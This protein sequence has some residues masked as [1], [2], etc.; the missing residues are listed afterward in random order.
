MT[1]ITEITFLSPAA[2]RQAFTTHSLHFHSC[3]KQFICSRN[4]F[5]LMPSKWKNIRPRFAHA[6]RLSNLWCLFFSKGEWR[7]HQTQSL[8]KLSERPT[9][10]QTLEDEQPMRCIRI[11]HQGM[12][13]SSIRV[14]CV[15][16]HGVVDANGYVL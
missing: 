2:G 7:R 12:H 8:P 5:V 1:V 4:T 6:Y 3:A 14:P 13:I 11:R 10:L 15:Q 16:L 9:G